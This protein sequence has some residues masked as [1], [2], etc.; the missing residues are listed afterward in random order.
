[1]AANPKLD[2]YL[3]AALLVT[4][5][6]GCSMFTDTGLAAR[7]AR[8]PG[9]PTAPSTSVPQANGSTVPARDFDFML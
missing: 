5:I 1:M 4:M 2:T 6:S 7:A 3:F 8:D 9:S